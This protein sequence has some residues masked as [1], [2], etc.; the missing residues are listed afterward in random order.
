MR[1]L[2]FMLFMIFPFFGISQNISQTEKIEDFTILKKSILKYYS[3]YD[4]K[5][6]VTGINIKSFLEQKEEYLK[7]NN[8]SDKEFVYIVNSALTYCQDQHTGMIW[9]SFLDNYDSLIV[10][11][12]GKYDRDIIDNR[13]KQLLIY[14]S[15]NVPND[16]Y[17][18]ISCNYLDGNYYTNLPIKYKGK[19]YEYGLRILKMNNKSIDSIVLENL[20]NIFC[21]W[22]FKNKKYYSELF[23]VSESEIFNRDSVSYT[24]LNHNQDTIRIIYAIGESDL[25]KY[26]K[27]R[28]IEINI[29]DVKYFKK[30]KILY[31]RLLA[32]HFFYPN[33]ILSKIQKIRNKEIDKVVIDIRG[34]GGGNDMVWLSVISSIIDKP[35]KI[36]IN[37][38]TQNIEQSK[39][40]YSDVISDNTEVIKVPYSQRDFY[41]I[42]WGADIKKYFQPNDSSLNY[43]G[44]IYVIQDK[45]IFSGAVSLSTLCLY[46]DRFISIGEEN[47]KT[48]SFGEEPLIY[49][50]PNSQIMYRINATVDFTDINK[51]K[52][53]YN[54]V[55]IPLQY[56]IDDY[57]NRASKQLSLYSKHFLKTKDPFFKY[58]LN[59][60]TD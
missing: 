9:Y 19:R 41:R 29:N 36:N 25:I 48:G 46:S 44:K 57:Y 13:Q 51:L 43:S 26:K 58:I 17:Q 35:L 12:F 14:I 11:S 22:D 52:D 20:D 15:D 21:N 47:G 6:K 50:L 59:L 49:I 54:S 45:D 32:M 33:K 10:N 56:S 37:I 4:I 31:V 55:E 7:R 2:I 1:S 8:V 42:D 24:L 23:S 16:Y 40:F 18:A 60:P 53:Y 3:H 28:W 34:N 27:A 30:E 5:E 38:A 39:L